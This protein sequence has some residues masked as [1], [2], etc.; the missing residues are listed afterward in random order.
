MSDFD[1]N[2]KIP[3]IVETKDTIMN[4][5]VQNKNFCWRRLNRLKGREGKLLWKVMVT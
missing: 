4:Q 3:F 5:N 2:N 1:S